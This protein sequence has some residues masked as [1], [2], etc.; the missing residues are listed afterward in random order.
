MNILITP[1]VHEWAIGKLTKSII[2]H[3]PRFN[4]F[5]ISVHPRG[6]IEG[7][8]KITRLLRDGVKIDL[9]HAQYWNSA[10]QAMDLV[11]ELKSVPKVLTHQNH[12]A[13]GER[14]W[15]EFDSI[16]IPTEWGKNYLEKK[17]ANVV[18]IPYGIDLDTYSFINEYP[19]AEPAVGYIGRV[20]PHKNLEE[21]CRVSKELGYK[22]IGVDIVP[23]MIT[24]A[25]KIARKK[26]LSIKYRVGDAAN[27][28]FRDDS[29]DN[30]LIPES[31]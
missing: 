18:K 28:R 22:G 23:A 13:L 26:K 8:G 24:N 15:N 19:P 20:V 12:Y 16:V 11:R 4:F 5:N 14:E 21:I 3:N 17:N 31:E 25:K 10:Y 30:A 1:D 29:F 7:V 2:R 6:V 27:L 9:W